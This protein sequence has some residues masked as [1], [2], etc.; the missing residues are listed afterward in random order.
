LEVGPTEL[1]LLL[2]IGNV[3]LFYRPVVTLFGHKYC[4]STSAAS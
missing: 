3:A 4:F 2:M 1:R